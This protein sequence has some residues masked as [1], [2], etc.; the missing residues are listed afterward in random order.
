VRIPFNPGQVYGI[1]GIIWALPGGGAHQETWYDA[2]QSGRWIKAGQRDVQAVG[3]DQTSRSIN[4][5]NT[6]IEF[7]VDCANIT[8]MHTDVA[9]IRPGGTPASAG[10]GYI[11]YAG[12]NGSRRFKHRASMITDHGVSAPPG[13]AHHDNIED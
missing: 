2:N 3:K 11:A 1:K 13:F 5:S 6:Q 9:E 4:P 7:R 10:A 12:F 8:Y